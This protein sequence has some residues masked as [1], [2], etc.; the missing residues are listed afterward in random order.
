MKRPI[1]LFILLT[2]LGAGSPLSAQGSDDEKNL[3]ELYQQID[4]AIDQFPQ[5][6]AKRLSQ[7]ADT[8]KMLGSDNNM[9]KRFALA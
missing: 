8:R 9:E 2:I 6:V 1:A 7:I 5:Y 4:E 3:Q